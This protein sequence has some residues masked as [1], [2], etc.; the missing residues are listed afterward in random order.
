MS[1]RKRVTVRVDQDDL[2][3]LRRSETELRR[4]RSDVPKLFSD[5]NRDFQN[6]LRPLQERQ[7]RFENSVGNLQADV[8]DLE[9]DTARRLQEQQRT[10]YQ[11]L[12]KQEKRFDKEIHALAKNTERMIQEE[13]HIREEQIRQVSAAIDEESRVRRQQVERV[14]GE[15]QQVR[16][17]I[18]AKEAYRNEVATTWIDAAQTIYDF[19]TANYRHEHFAPNRVA[20]L[21]RSI[22]Q[23]RQN[24]EQNLPEPAIS[25]AQDAYRQLSDLRLELEQ[26]EQEWQM[27]LNAALSSSREL[28]E[29]AHTNR[30]CKAL[31]MDGNVEQDENG[32]DVDVEVDFW[33]NG[34]LSALEQKL[35]AQIQQLEQDNTLTTETFRQIVEQ[36]NPEFQQEL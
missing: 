12:E 30:Q 14:A 31:D 7:N 35:Q 19:I 24:V 33:T 5:V 17:D 18:Q 23:A 28:F 21:E 11:K 16:D 3:R 13:R 15:I 10:M 2:N 29:Q 26:L 36:S 1:G 34:S 20:D 25:Q 9:R 22:Q 32:K 8:R 6:R 4:I 27:W